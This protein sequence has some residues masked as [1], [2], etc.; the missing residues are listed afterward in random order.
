MA[1]QSDQVPED[2]FSALNRSAIEYLQ[3]KYGQN[4]QVNSTTA[5][6]KSVIDIIARDNIKESGITLVNADGEYC[7]QSFDRTM[8]GYGRAYDKCSDT[9]TVEAVDPAA[10]SA[11]AAGLAGGEGGG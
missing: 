5:A 10:L 6:L 7:K 4:L 1:Q 11:Q 2:G 9:F 3:G 8:P